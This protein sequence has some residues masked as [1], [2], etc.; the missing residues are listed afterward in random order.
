M[1]TI[2]RTLCIVALVFALTA[3]CGDEEKAT[4]TTTPTSAPASGA[5]VSTTVPVTVAQR[6]TDG[7]ICPTPNA[8][9]S[10]QTSGR[11]MVCVPIAGGNELRWRPA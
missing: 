8:R 11:A 6:V 2:H 9:G 7:A 1:R 10:D 5:P 3:A 4:P